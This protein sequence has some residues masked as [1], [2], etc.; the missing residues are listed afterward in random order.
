LSIYIA[1]AVSALIDGIFSGYYLRTGIDASP[2][3]IGVRI[4]ETLEPLLPSQT[5]PQAEFYK[6]LIIVIPWVI[7]GITILIAP[8]RIVGLVIFVV[9]FAATILFVGYYNA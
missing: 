5:I 9:V 4:I 2:S 1:I 7:A 6:L 3:A 8:N